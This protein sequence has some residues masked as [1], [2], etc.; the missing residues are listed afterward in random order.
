MP[1][2]ERLHISF[3]LCT[4]FRNMK[5]S[6]DAVLSIEKEIEQ[7]EKEMQDLME[8]LSTLENR[9]AEVMNSCK[10]AEV[11]MLLASVPQMEHGLR[12]SEQY[13]KCTYDL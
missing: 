10:K 1:L 3:I 7:N 2:E 8:Q 5:K 6:E 4:V 11:C 12:D 9:A 13:T